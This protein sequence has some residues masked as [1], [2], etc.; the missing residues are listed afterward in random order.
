MNPDDFFNFIKK[1]LET[2]LGGPVEGDGSM[3][4]PIILRGGDGMP[5]RQEQYRAPFLDVIEGNKNEITIVADLSGANA[6]DIVC[7]IVREGSQNYLV[8]STIDSL[9][10]KYN[11]DIPLGKKRLEIVSTLFNNGVFEV[12]LK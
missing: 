1:M 6:D 5:N 11:V 12:T 7:K 2:E 10:E 9:A 3:R 8:I 4:G